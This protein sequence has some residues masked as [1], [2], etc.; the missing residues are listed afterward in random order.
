[1]FPAI[2]LINRMHVGVGVISQKT[3]TPLHWKLSMQD[4]QVTLVTPPGVCH[5]VLVVLSYQ[6]AFLTK[7]RRKGKKKHNSYQSA[8]SL[9]VSYS[10]AHV[11]N[12]CTA[13]LSCE[14]WH[15]W[16]ALLVALTDQIK[17][18]SDQVAEPA[19]FSCKKIK[20]I[21]RSWIKFILNFEKIY[22]KVVGQFTYKKNCMLFLHDVT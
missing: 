19:F 15:G 5:F 16:M 20:I 17:T 2:I 6:S 10:W 12:A 13:H 11:D 22:K 3:I 14:M 1:M 4:T 21:G 18:H 7:N 8:I 9:H